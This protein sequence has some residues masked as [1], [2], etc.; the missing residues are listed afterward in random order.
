MKKMKNLKKKI[1]LALAIIVSVA[2]FSGC[3][4]KD[5]AADGKINLTWMMSGS[6]QSDSEIVWEKFN[7]ELN[8]RPGF[9]NYKLDFNLIPFADFSQKFM[10]F[11]TSG[12]KM[13]IVSTY[14]LNF[15]GEVRNGT[16][17]D[18]TDDMETCAPDVLKEIPAW[19]LKLCQVDNRQY[20]ITNYQQMAGAKYESVGMEY[21]LT[22]EKNKEPD[23]S[24]FKNATL[25]K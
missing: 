8:K 10:L 17:Y 9:E 4:G 25:S 23:L 2:S 12:E 1:C 20:A 22:K 7:E 18:M 16:L 15:S 3:G 11:Q 13:D 5:K 24:I 6:E 19:A 21:S 14:N